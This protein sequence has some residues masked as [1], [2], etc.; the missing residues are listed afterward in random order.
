MTEA[1]VDG[2]GAILS[3]D[4]GWKHRGG[5]TRVSFL[6]VLGVNWVRPSPLTASVVL[7][8]VVTTC[9]KHISSSVVMAVGFYFKKCVYYSVSLFIIFIFKSF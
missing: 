8:A 3:K 5:D 7:S 2:P 6:L 4:A 9:S 1:A